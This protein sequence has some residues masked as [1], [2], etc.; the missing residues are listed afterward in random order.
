TVT[1]REG[2]KRECLKRGNYDEHPTHTVTITRPFYMGEYEVTNVQYEQFDPGHR[3]YRG[4]RDYSIGDDDAVIM[5]SW[6]DAAAF[7]RWLSK[8][9][10]RTYRLPTEAEWE[11]ACRAGTTGPFNTARLDSDVPNKWGL[12]N[13]HGGVEEWCNDWYGP[14]FDGPQT[15]PVGRSDGQFKVIRGGSHGAA[16]FYMRSANRSGSITDDKSELIGFRV[17]LADMPTSRMLPPARQPYQMNVSQKVPADLTSGPDKTVPY[18]VIRRYVNIP[19]GAAGPLFYLH[20]HNPDIVQCPNGDLLAIHF[21]TISEGDREMV[22]GG[23]RLRY[24]NEK[25]D[26][27]SVFWAPPDRK[28]EYSVLW[29]DGDTIYNFS[30]LGV[31]NSRPSAIVMRTSKDNG[32]TWSDPRTIVPRADNQGVMQTVFRTRRRAIVIPADDH[33]LFVSHDNGLTWSS[34]C[35]AKGPAGIHTPMVEMAD[36]GLMAFGRYDDIDGMMPKSVSVDMGKTWTHSASVFTPIGG[37]QRATM[38]RLKEGPIFFASFAK[39]MTMIDGEGAE[40]ECNGLFAALS[41]DEGKNWP[42]IRLIS[43]GS[44]RRVFTRKNKYYQMA[45]NRSE[46]NGYLASCQSADGVIHMVSNRVEYAFNLKWLWRE[47][48]L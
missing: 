20:N 5:V 25:W 28:A 22:Y 46:G 35:S 9:E 41:F 32:V 4:T 36:G 13:M 29:V 39:K 21:S 34:P 18:F 3:R 45:R 15:D 42:V 16:P 10:R 1:H 48:K 30:S 33:N 31:A 47:Y 23:S 24:G 6:E 2:K 26:D 14:Y 37:G 27:T 38:L 17:V 40:S 43:D 19:Q 7:C 44:G 8:K 11:Y 12:F